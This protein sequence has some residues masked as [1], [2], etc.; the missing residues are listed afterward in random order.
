[1]KFSETFVL[2][3]LNII[4]N[5]NYKVVSKITY[6]KRL[7][8]YPKNLFIKVKQSS[9]VPGLGWP[10]GFQEVKVPIFLDNG[11]GWW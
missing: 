1:L 8:Y 2:I 10:R 4:Y 6:I 5:F 11:T 9:P 3:Q 7:K